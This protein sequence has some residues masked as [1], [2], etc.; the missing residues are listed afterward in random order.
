M[1]C[2]G[3]HKWKKMSSE[4]LAWSWDR[5]HSCSHSVEHTKS[6][7]HSQV[8]RVSH[9]LPDLGGAQ[10]QSQSQV[11][12][13]GNVQL[14]FLSWVLRKQCQVWGEFRLCPLL[15]RCYCL[16]LP[17]HLVLQAFQVVLRL[18][19]VCQVRL[20]QFPGNFPTLQVSSARPLRWHKTQRKMV[21][22]FWTNKQIS[23]EYSFK[24]LRVLGIN[25]KVYPLI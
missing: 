7:P 15:A 1:G 18:A 22:L 25:T 13:S 10:S 9:G 11:I 8:L 24:T 17:P 21:S 14:L 3:P 16:P 23:Y 2:K 19:W 6:S 5:K 12:F 20:S 4:A